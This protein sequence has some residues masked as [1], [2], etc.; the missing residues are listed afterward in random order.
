MSATPR[1]FV[2][3]TSRDLGSFRKAASEVL[4]RKHVLPVD[5]DHAV[6]D[7]QSVEQSLRKRIIGCDAVIC[8]VGH[9]YGREPN[10]RP[11]TCQRRSYTQM[12]YD[13]AIELG[14]PLFLFLAT[15]DCELDVRRD[16]IQ[17]PEELQTLQRDYRC[18]LETLDRLRYEFRS[19]EQLRAEIALIEFDIGSL[20]AAHSQSVQPDIEIK[21]APIVRTNRWQTTIVS[22]AC[23]SAILLGVLVYFRPPLTEYFH[24]RVAVPDG[25]ELVEAI[26]SQ[27]NATADEQ[28]KTT[29]PQGRLDL[30]LIE[31]DREYMLERVDDLAKMIQDDLKAGASATYRRAINLLADR[32]SGSVDAAILSLKKS[33]DGIDTAKRDRRALHLEA[34]LLEMRFQWELAASLL[35]QVSKLDPTAFDVS[36]DLGVVHLRLESFAE[37][38]KY[39]RAA[40]VNAANP[41]NEV[42]ALKSLVH[43]LRQT[44]RIEDAITQSCRCVTLS[45]QVMGPAHPDV[46]KELEELIRLSSQQFGTGSFETG[47]LVRRT[48][49][50]I[51]GFY[52]GEHKDLPIHLESLAWAFFPMLATES[53]ELAR[54]ALAI[55]EKLLGTQ[56]RTV[57]YNIYIVALSLEQLG[58]TDESEILLRRSVRL[59]DAHASFLAETLWKKWQ[60]NRLAPKNEAEKISQADQLVEIEQLMRRAITQTQLSDEPSSIDAYRLLQLARL[61]CAT[62]RRNVAEQLLRRYAIIHLQSAEKSGREDPYFRNQITVLGY[63]DKLSQWEL[64]ARVTDLPLPPITLEIEQWLGTASRE[65]MLLQMDS[66]AREALVPVV[67][68]AQS[69]QD[70]VPPKANDG[71]PN[72]PAIAQTDAAAVPDNPPQPPT[73]HQKA[74]ERSNGAKMLREV[75]LD[76]PVTPLLDR[77][78]GPARSISQILTDLDK[79]N[80]E[81]ERP[82]VWFLPLSENIGPQLRELVR[83]SNRAPFGVP[84]P[85]GQQ[86]PVPPVED[87][88]K[89]G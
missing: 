29:D 18:E 85:A 75:P 31:E 22:I 89:P 24:D 26:R 15:D 84:V 27:I 58:Y 62:N 63:S 79:Q 60:Q 13:I 68:E 57:G 3:A 20:H 43:L 51:D 23:L 76:Q 54:H 14:K 42:T 6:P 48:L 72:S 45:E 2:S 9:L 41:R 53:L 46:A 71:T 87:A 8:L 65:K 78:L 81:M 10:G 34:K 82:S 25:A 69:P 49:A 40:L 77:M 21:R 56:H 19:V 64:D 73:K 35:E 16:Q 39:L 50:I 37:A 66:M 74:V 17:E 52:K 11:A 47:P 32:K 33:R 36:H 28:L 30:D 86:A 5:Q 44:G 12:E 80:H 38:E 61:L 59:N 7:Y 83:P 88:P 70:E 4:V 55:N 67:P 1:V